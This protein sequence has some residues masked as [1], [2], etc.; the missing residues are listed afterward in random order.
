MNKLYCAV[1]THLLEVV[2]TLVLN[3]LLVN[4]VQRENSIECSF[5]DKCIWQKFQIYCTNAKRKM[6]QNTKFIA[7]TEVKTRINR[8]A[9]LILFNLETLRRS[10]SREERSEI[11]CN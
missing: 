8:Q 3:I 6:G 4:C 1:F 2:Q 7:S 5:A 10:K 9:E 11:L